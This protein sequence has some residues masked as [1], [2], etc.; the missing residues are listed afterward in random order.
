MKRSKEFFVNL[1]WDDLRQWAGVKILNRG[2]SYVKNVSDLAGT[3]NGEWVAW[4]AGTEDYATCVYSDDQ[5][6]IDWDCTCPYDWGPCKHAVAVILAGIE[7]SKKGKE[8]P[9]LEKESDLY[10]ALWEDPDEYEDDFVDEDDFNNEEASPKKNQGSDLEKIL[11]KKNKEELVTLLIDMATHHPQVG[12]RI[13]EDGQL[14][15][16]QIGKLVRA[17]RNE[18]KKVTN[19]EAWYSHWNDEGNLP[20]YSHI[21]EQLTVLFKKGHA[22]AVVELGRELWERGNQQV[23][24]SDDE[25][26]CAEQI[27]K[28]MDVVFQAVCSSSLSAP[29]QL[30]WMIDIF[31]EDEF[32]ISGSSEKLLQRKE[33]TKEHWALAGQ[34]LQKRLAVTPQQNGKMFSSRYQRSRLMDWLVE[35]YERSGQKDK[36]IPL[37]EQEVQATQSY[38]KLATAY[39]RSG[40]PE[41]AREWCI[42]G[43]KDTIGDAP[44]IAHGLRKLL[45]ELAATEKK[46]DLVA[47]YFAEEF[48][49]QPCQASYTTLQ[50]AAEKIKAW[51]EVR[52]AVLRFLET[53]K[54]PGL[55]PKDK[56]SQ[57][58]PL[59]APEV[60]ESKGSHSRRQYPDLNI[61]IDIAILEKRLDDVVQLYQEQQKTIRWG[62][63][64][65]EKVAAAVAGTHPDIALGIWKHIAVSRI[66]LVK[67]KAYEEAAVFLRKMRTVY[68]KTKRIDEWQKLIAT[69][70]IE[71]KPKRRL[72]EVLDSLENKR[73]ID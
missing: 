13:L 35:S 22:D 30:L 19:E 47:S 10:M 1:T 69:L 15:A 46:F 39:I 66:N 67:P 52:A 42:K 32:S 61:L 72:M 56:R 7:Q 18:I 11:R 8:L 40:H 5:G 14:A 55:L 24:E 53:G 73:I 23:E 36:I 25:G 4:V 3:E 26:H 29:E 33:Y 50:K 57:S 48:I 9:L 44:G 38:Q 41:K 64:R 12:R 68:Q 6:K 65:G 70:R 51:P 27:G 20:D 28:C 63:G 62:V 54:H 45:C 71:H 34:E 17:L 21:W 16:G 43:Y 37:Y 49:D 31:L 58:W 2:K 60:R 59:P